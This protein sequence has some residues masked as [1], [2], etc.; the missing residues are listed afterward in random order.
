MR[1]RKLRIAWT[2]GWII[3]SLTFLYAWRRSQ[4]F[5]DFVVCF[6]ASDI[7]VMGSDCGEIYLAPHA[8]PGK[9]SDRTNGWGYYISSA[10]PTLNELANLP[11]L[12]QRTIH[13]PY[14]SLVAASFTLAA[15][16]WLRSQ[17]SL[18]TLLIAT[19]LVAVVLGLAAW[20]GR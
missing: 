3:I 4:Q 7:A 19:T 18:R 16:P 15:L 14:W 1:F 5:H 13:S 11:I 10:R 9:L 17:F 6:R 8:Y 12:S 20:A 2:V